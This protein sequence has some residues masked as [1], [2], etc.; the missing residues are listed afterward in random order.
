MGRK[1]TDAEFSLR[2]GH[3]QGSKVLQLLGR[4]NV[5]VRA[6]IVKAARLGP[7]PL[8]ILADELCEPVNFLLF[9]AGVSVSVHTN[10]HN[11]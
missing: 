6:Q 9:A 10:G 2:R 5:D 3:E 11:V 1:G 4:E 7:E 8:E